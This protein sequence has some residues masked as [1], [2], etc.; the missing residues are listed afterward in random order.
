[1]ESLYTAGGNYCTV[2]PSAKESKLATILSDGL[3]RPGRGT[4]VSHPWG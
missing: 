1:M 3:A 2:N 4:A